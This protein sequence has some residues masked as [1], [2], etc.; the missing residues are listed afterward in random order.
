MR[1]IFIGLTALGLILSACSPA[2]QTPAAQAFGEPQIP[3]SEVP[4]VGLKEA[5]A[6]FDSSSAVFV[7]VRSA[8]SYAD[9]HIPGALSI[10]EFEIQ[11]R[12][13]ELDPSRWIITYCT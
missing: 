10:P 12:R 7:D 11:S 13:G 1:R 5:K 3:Q 9:S 8:G 6:A 2:T 4:R